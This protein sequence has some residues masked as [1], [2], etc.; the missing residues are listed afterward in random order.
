MSAHLPHN[1]DS[2][3]MKMSPCLIHH[4]IEVVEVVCERHGLVRPQG[5]HGEDDGLVP[6]RRQLRHAPQPRLEDAVQERL[7]RLQEYLMGCNSNMIL[8]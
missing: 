5:L 6:R 3:Y 1:Q 4:L 7:L 2:I 8:Y